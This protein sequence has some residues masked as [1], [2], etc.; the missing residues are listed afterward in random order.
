MRRL[1]ILLTFLGLIS[2]VEKWPQ[3]TVVCVPLDHGFPNHTLRD[4]RSQR[5]SKREDRLLVPQHHYPG[6][7]HEA[8]AYFQILYHLSRINAIFKYCILR[9]TTWTRIPFSWTLTF[10]TGY[11]SIINDFQFLLPS[12]QT[13]TCFFINS[14]FLTFAFKGIM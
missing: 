11:Q 3:W 13:P 7:S 4:H 10:V 8:R 1:N 5:L 6:A 14:S 9:I 2:N 12:H